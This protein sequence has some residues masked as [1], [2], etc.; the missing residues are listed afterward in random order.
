M[1]LRDIEQHNLVIKNYTLVNSWKA[2]RTAIGW[3]I[4]LTNIT[5]FNYNNYNI[6]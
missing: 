1:E 4:H 5:D 2:D 6:L 3:I